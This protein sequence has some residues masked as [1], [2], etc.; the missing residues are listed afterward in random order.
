[1]GTPFQREWIGLLCDRHRGIGADGILVFR[2]NKANV[3]LDHHDPDGTNSFC[4]NGLRA[5]LRCLYQKNLVPESGTVSS[6]G[7]ELS[8]QRGGLSVCLP[9]LHYHP[10]TVTGPSFSI[11]G[12]KLDVG[13]PQFVTLVPL[14]DRRFTEM[15]PLVR[16]NATIFPQGANI[17][18]LRRIKNGWRIRTFER[19]VEGFTLACGSGMYAAALTLFGEYGGSKLHFFPEGGGLI[20]IEKIGDQLIFESAVHWTASG[21]WRCGSF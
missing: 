8:Y 2:G 20:S 16:Q 4:L 17:N 11:A 5:S 7:V 6:E 14:E 13:N 10:V 9:L 1:M 19:G 12:F 15:A 3:V 21:V 18:H